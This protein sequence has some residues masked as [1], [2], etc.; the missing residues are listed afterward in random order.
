MDRLRIGIVGTSSYTERVH[1]PCLTSHEHATIITIC[2]RRRERAEELA[3]KYAV[4]KVFTDFTEMVTSRCIEA[5]VIATPDD[6][7][8]SMALAALK[9]GLHV[10][11]KKPL[12][13]NATQARAMRDRAAAAQVK[14]MVYF[15]WRWIP[16][17]EHLH[18]LVM[19]GWIGRPQHWTLSYLGNY[20]RRPGYAWRF[21]ESRA[22]GVLGDLG[23]H[24]LDLALWLGG[25]IN[26]VAAQLSTFVDRSGPDSTTL[27]K[28]NDT[29]TLL[30]R[31]SSGAQGAIHLS[32]V[33]Q[34][35][36]ESQEQSIVV[37]GSEGRLQVIFPRSTG[38]IL[39]G[40]RDGKPLQPIAVPDDF[41]GD[42]GES[43]DTRML[44][45]WATCSVADRL[46]I[47]AILHGRPL[48]PT[49][50]DGA[51]VQEI[52]DAALAAS[53]GGTWVTV[54]S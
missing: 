38:P 2:G 54:K 43:Y 31:F 51:K 4:A 13:V 27:L 49:F 46:F 17:Y 48:A 21:D 36:T 18:R 42:N 6:L 50:D 33:A 8:Y 7:H 20:G 19:E 29:A 5:V 12:A 45:A 14:H 9:A 23:S 15:R 25:D 53:Q 28:G 35:G 37:H 3:R 44:T 39:Y 30:L 52:I 10:L 16:Q 1:L 32:A 26:S 24:M 41:P 11:C 47:D 22:T 34:L 40:T